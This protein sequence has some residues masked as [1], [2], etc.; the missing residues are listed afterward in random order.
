MKNLLKILAYMLSFWFYSLTFAWTI[1]HF[2]VQTNPSSVKVWESIDITI[3]ALDKNGAVVKN[4]VWEILIFSQ[5]DPKAEFPGVLSGN[6][7]TFKTWD[8]WVV[9]FENAVKF[10]QKWTQ[11]INVYD[12]SNENI[13]GYAEVVVWEWNT[14][15]G[16]W[17]ISIT[18]PE[19]WITL[20]KN[21][22]KVSGKTLKN[23]KVKITLNK[24]KTFDAISD[25]KWAFEVEVSNIPSWENVL[26]ATLID[27]DDKVIW[28]STDVL[29]K[30]ET[31]IPSFKSIKLNPSLKEVTPE[32]II[33]VELDATNSLTTVNLIVNDVIFTLKETSKAWT[34]SWSITAPKEDW[35]YK[36]DLIMKNELWTESKENWIWTI[37]V[38]T[39]QLNAANTWTLEINCDDF[40]KELEIK[41]I[42]VVKLKS[43][44]V[45]SWDKVNKAS[46]YN[47]YKKDRN[48]TWMTLIENILNNN[49]EIE[50]V[51]DIVEYDDFIVKAVFKDDV[52]NVEWEA[53]S[54]TK[55]QTWPKE[56][57]FIV[58]LI[59]LTIWIF[60]LRK[61]SV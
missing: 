41:N 8:A 3:K 19:A 37:I 46:S 49:Y 21:N 29:F 14:T 44:S 50:I 5:S 45:L 16:T 53:S 48:W 35:E 9:K 26:K 40:K 27:A 11:D 36:I 28:E 56:L 32:T 20:W 51:W 15:I 22:I 7:Y 4:Y 12:I 47:I 2:D 18:Y 13:F 31:N 54:M 58:I 24:N 30:V 60:L 39:P 42:K 23:H 34:Y 43:K 38:K 52:C 57:L 1:D 33:N 25:S 6:T 10:T 59:S 17:E 55:V 61:R